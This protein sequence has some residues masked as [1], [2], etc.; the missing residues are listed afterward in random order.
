MSNEFA[1]EQHLDELGV[2]YEI[3]PCDP[4]LADTQAFCAN[5]PAYRHPFT[6]DKGNIQVM[7]G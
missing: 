5:Q 4:A 1:I 3:I 2:P 7:D 6:I